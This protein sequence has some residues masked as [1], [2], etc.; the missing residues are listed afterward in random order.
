MRN[1]MSAATSTPIF[2][3]P[4][5]AT[6]TRTTWLDQWTIA[7]KPEFNGKVNI[8]M[9]RTSMRHQIID[10]LKEAIEVIK[11]YKIFNMK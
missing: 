6:I 4:D 8:A 5:D 9:K 11:S 2:D 3:Y 1:I 7:I 10:L